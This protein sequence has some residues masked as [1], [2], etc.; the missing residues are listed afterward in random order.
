MTAHDLFG[1]LF[2]LTGRFNRAK[3]WLSVVATLVIALVMWLI[4]EPLALG[5]Q[6]SQPSP[7]DIVLSWMTDKVLFIL[8]AIQ[9]LIMFAAGTKRL[10][11]LNRTAAWL[12]LFI[13]VPVLMIIILATYIVVAAVAIPA[14][15]TFE[16]VDFMRFAG[17][18]AIV[19]AIW[20][21]I[22][23]WALIW[24]GCL[25]GTTGPNRYGPDPLEGR[26]N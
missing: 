24:L 22:E 25:G 16:K 15:Q 10:H 19:A 11:D 9:L 3:W 20:L 5:A 17:A 13:G 6:P 4:H 2:G 23:I 12:V 14:G 8:F 21:A 1:F 7:W 18:A 26:P